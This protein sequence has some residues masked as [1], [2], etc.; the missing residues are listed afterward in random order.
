MRRCFGFW[1]WI[2]FFG[3]AHF[4]SISLSMLLFVLYE[5]RRQF[6]YEQVSLL[7]FNRSL[8]SW[9][10]EQ[11][12][13]RI[14]LS[15]ERIIFR[16][17]VCD[18][19]LCVFPYVR[20]GPF[21]RRSAHE[22]IVNGRCCKCVYSVFIYDYDDA[23]AYANVRPPAGPSGILSQPKIIEPNKNTPE[24][25][26]NEIFVLTGRTVFSA[27]N[28]QFDFGR[29]YIL[30]IPIYNWAIIHLLLSSYCLA[31][32]LFLHCFVRDSSRFLDFCSFS[33]HY[34]LSAWTR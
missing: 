23:G 17:C 13:E 7:S 9:R 27:G 15:G 1:R 14:Y 5:R 33:T 24:I 20:C 4:D 21:V 25:N 32:K 3:V 11:L 26:D 12:W 31:A 10:S 2:C 29:T 30:I 8:I 34:L 6:I 19:F 18:G 16:I 22:L 28:V